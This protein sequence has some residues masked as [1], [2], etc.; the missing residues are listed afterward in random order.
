MDLRGEELRFEI[1]NLL[2]F[3]RSRQCPVALRVP[4]GRVQGLVRQ[5]AEK[6]S[7]VIVVN[8]FVCAGGWRRFPAIKHDR[9]QER[10]VCCR[11]RPPVHRNDVGGVASVAV[12]D[13]DHLVVGV[14]GNGDSNAN[15]SPAQQ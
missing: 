12:V 14:C 9:A 1:H 8:D 6:R 4:D 5:I 15:Q 7:W 11:Q 3:F 2:L 13:A 10:K